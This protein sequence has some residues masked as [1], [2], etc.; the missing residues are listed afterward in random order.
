MKEGQCEEVLLLLL[1]T[2]GTCNRRGRPVLASMPGKKLKIFTMLGLRLEK[3]IFLVPGP[4]NHI[5][6]DVSR[7]TSTRITRKT[8]QH[9]R[10]Q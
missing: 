3:L 10:G 7:P 8:S 2:L 5:V 6:G 1:K 9:L 4:D